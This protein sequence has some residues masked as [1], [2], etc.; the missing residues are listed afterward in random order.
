MKDLLLEHDRQGKRSDS[1]A[2]FLLLSLT[3]AGIC[4]FQLPGVQAASLFMCGAPGSV[5]E[6]AK[7]RERPGPAA[8]SSLG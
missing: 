5:L 7:P 1:P 2:G 4:R 6:T 8:G 3:T